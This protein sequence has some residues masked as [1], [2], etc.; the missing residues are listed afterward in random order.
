MLVQRDEACSSPPRGRLA[1]PAWRPIR[2]SSVHSETYELVAPARA[3]NICRHPASAARPSLALSILYAL[4]GS[5]G[6]VSALFFG[7]AGRA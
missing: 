6:L 3:W 2:W 4:Y 7:L 1:L 5:L